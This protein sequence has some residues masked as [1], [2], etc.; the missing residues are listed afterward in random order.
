MLGKEAQNSATNASSSVPSSVLE[1]GFWSEADQAIKWWAKQGTS[2]S[3]ETSFQLLDALADLS[4]TITVQEPNP[5]SSLLNTKVLNQLVQNWLVALAREEETLSAPAVMAKLEAYRTNSRTTS[6]AKRN[7]KPQ[8]ETYQWLME[9][10]ARATPV[11]FQE[12]LVRHLMEQAKDDPEIQPDFKTLA[13]ILHGWSRRGQV[14]PLEE[15]RSVLALLQEFSGR[16]DENEITHTQINK[17][18]ETTQFAAVELFN[19]ALFAISRGNSKDKDSKGA[20]KMLSILNFMEFVAKEYDTLNPSMDLHP[21]SDTYNLILH[22]FA[23]AGKGAQAEMILRSWVDRYS[24]ASLQDDGPV[25]KFAK[26]TSKSFTLVINAFGNSEENY[27]A[28][29]AEGILRWQQQENKVGPLKD[30]LPV[31]T[32]SYNNVIRAWS[33][34]RSDKGIDRC[35]HLRKEMIEYNLAPDIQTYGQSLKGIALSNLPE[36]GRRAVKV[37][38]EMEFRG[39][40]ANDY[41]QSYFEKCV[42]FSSKPSSPSRSKQYGKPKRQSKTNHPYLLSA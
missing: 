30:C 29:K 8:L 14:V 36:K 40:Q 38:R 18:D 37:W 32:I 22:A 23:R 19:K 15:L 13:L 25:S 16:S 39:I 11:G 42:A 21:T 20:E 34:R 28:E 12:S 35:D 26:P 5:S 17:E 3:V 2:E 41:V 10:P 27:A 9:A 24:Q 1:K 4:S 33:W 7:L 6:R 31:E